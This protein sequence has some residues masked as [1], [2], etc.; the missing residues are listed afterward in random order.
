MALALAGASCRDE[1]VENL[2]RGGDDPA[3]PANYGV[4]TLAAG[5]IVVSNAQNPSLGDAVFVSTASATKGQFFNAGGA[6][7][8]Y[9]PPGVAQWDRNEPTS[10]TQDVAIIRINTGKVY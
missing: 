10:Q 2:T 9:L 7:L 4:L 1:H 5:R 3:Y 6:D 8:V